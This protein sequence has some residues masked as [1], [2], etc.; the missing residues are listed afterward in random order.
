[1]M[2]HLFYLAVNTKQGFMIKMGTGWVDFYDLFFVFSTRSNAETFS[3]DANLW[4][5]EITEL[6]S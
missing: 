4:Q 5:L 1:M 6:T 3:I 2:F